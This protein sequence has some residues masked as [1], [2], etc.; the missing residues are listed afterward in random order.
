MRLRAIGL[1]CLVVLALTLVMT[2]PLITDLSHSVPGSPGDNYE[3][4]YKLWWFEEA[5]FER[6]QSPFFIADVFYPTGYEVAL[7]ETTLANTVLGLP[8]TSALG[9]VVSYNLLLIWSFVLSGIGAFLFARYLTGSLVAG[10]LAGLIF[11][12]LPYRTGHVATGHLPLMATGWLPLMLLYVERLLRHRRHRDGAL[13]G[14]FYGL[15]ALSSWYYAYM[16]ALVAALYT[17]LRLWQE[18]RRSARQ[19]GVLPGGTA[20]LPALWPAALLG[21]LVAA[22]VMLPGLVPLLS[23]S[24]RGE[25][26]RSTLS[27]R[28]VDQW[29]ASVADFV[30]PSVMHP[31]WGEGLVALYPQNVHENLL[32]LGLLPLLLA[33]Y[34]VWKRRTATATAVAI[35]G[36]VAFVLAL[37]TTLHWA[38]EPVYIPVPEAVEQLFSRAM[39]ALTGKYA[40]NPAAYSSV[41]QNGRIVIPMPT[42]ALYLFLPFFNAMRVWARFGLIVGLAV[43]VLAGMGAR[44]I[45]AWPRWTTAG[46][47]VLVTAM[48]AVVLFEFCTAPYPFGVSAIGPQPVDTWLAAQAGDFAVLTLPEAKT[49]RGPALYAAREHGKTIAYGYGTY[50]PTAFR[51]WQQQLSGFPDAQSLRAINT[52]GIRYVVIG[53]RFYGDQESEMRAR[54]AATAGLRLIH[55]AQDNPVLRGDRLISLVRPSPIVPPTELF[56][57]VAYA[58]LIDDVAVYEVVGAP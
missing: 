57:G 39:Y 10:V 8:L 54:V 27:L 49:W 50:M 38:G 31:L 9:E 20:R 5:I 22:L 19:P 25:M 33:A 47:R 55:T 23:L 18:R 12:F 3:Y 40:L 34:A 32:G 1:F 45:V 21:V 15:L 14:L 46:R 24:A 44:S 36:V 26:A 29:S 2:Y 48:A 11:A 16:G 53:W 42:L 7:S 13:A 30:L 51:A 41:Q 28:Y 6:R 56:G 43:A 37:G 58:Y 17:A 52:A 35:V 4:V